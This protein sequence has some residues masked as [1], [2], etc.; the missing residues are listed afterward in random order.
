MTVDIHL[1]VLLLFPPL[2]VYV[3]S[4]HKQ[5]QIL[6]QSNQIATCRINICKRKILFIYYRSIHNL[7]TNSNTVTSFSSSTEKGETLAQ[8]K[9]ADILS[10]EVIINKGSN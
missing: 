10:T 7:S 6:K 2:H 3:N 5:M 1:P 4:L 8:F 9:F